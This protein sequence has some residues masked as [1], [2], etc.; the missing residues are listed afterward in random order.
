MATILSHGI[1]AASLGKVF[2]AQRMPIRFCVASVICAMLPDID[3]IGFQF[4]VH[5]GDMLGHRGITHSLAFALLVSLITVT[6]LFRHSKPGSKGFYSLL[7]YFF[8]VTISHGVLDAFTNGGLGVAFLAPFSNARFFFPWRPIEVSPIGLHFFS[9]RGLDVIL[10]EIVWIWIPSAL[11][12]MLA[13]A[14]RK[15]ARN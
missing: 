14:I 8:V 15:L 5:Y 11:V 1:A 3:V 13:W 4:G 12:M 10:S 2:T 9:S 6:L 7:I